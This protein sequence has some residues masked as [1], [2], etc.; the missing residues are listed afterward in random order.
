MIRVGDIIPDI[1]S[2]NK[3]G[4]TTIWQTTH[5]IFKDKKILLIGLPGLFLVEYAAS[6]LRTYDFYAARIIE[7]GID[8]I[9][10]T[11]VDN[12]YAQ[13]AYAKKEGLSNIGN[14]PDPVGEWA[15][16]TGMLEDMSR[17]GLGDKCSHRY[18]MIIDNLI[19]K[20]CK[21]EDFTHNPMTCFQVTDADTTIKYL[22]IIQTNYE[23]W[24]DD[25]RNKVDV[26]GRDKI[27]SVL[28]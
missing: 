10:F 13:K 17:E 22:E 25:A 26:L 18:A 6:Q 23:R 5:E 12:C 1:Q 9:W 11:S 20:S 8:E 24:D 7:L 16:L 28:S 21:Y 2:M 27:N 14:L 15:K 3:I 4:T 19:M